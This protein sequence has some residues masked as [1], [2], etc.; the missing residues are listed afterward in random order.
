MELLK[1]SRGCSDEVTADKEDDK[2]YYT[3]VS[4]K[5]YGN[6]AAGTPPWYLIHVYC[7]K[8]QCNSMVENYFANILVTV[9]AKLRS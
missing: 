1:V 8:D 9:G 7:S 2:V 6:V 4:S 5:T 3:L